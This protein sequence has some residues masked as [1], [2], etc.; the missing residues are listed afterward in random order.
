MQFT[1][2]R[3]EKYNTIKFNSGKT[4]FDYSTGTEIRIFSYR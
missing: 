1:L 3:Q 4:R 2:D